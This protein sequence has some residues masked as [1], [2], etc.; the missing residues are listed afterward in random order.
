[1]AKS[2]GVVFCRRAKSLIAHPFNKLN[3]G[4]TEDL[5]TGPG[6]KKKKGGGPCR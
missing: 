6:S 1:L 4:E 2:L 5:N 3:G